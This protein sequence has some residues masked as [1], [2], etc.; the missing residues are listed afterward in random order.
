MALKNENKS[1]ISQVSTFVNTK[2]LKIPA[3]PLERKRLE[4]CLY[5]VIV[6]WT[7]SKLEF[8][9]SQTKHTYKYVYSCS[10]T[11]KP[12]LILEKLNKNIAFRL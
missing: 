9:N 2:F 1:K 3:S 8:E 5:K 11:N 6:Y 4:V 12:F 10:E 7:G